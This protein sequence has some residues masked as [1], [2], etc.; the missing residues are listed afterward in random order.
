[1]L[2]RRLFLALIKGPLIG[3]ALAAL[4]VFGLGIVAFGPLL[5]YLAAAATGVATGAL[6]GKPFWAKDAKLE[7]GLKAVVGAFMAVTAMFALRKWLS[8]DL[9]LSAFGA[10]K[11]PL[12]DLPAA[13]L[14]LISFVLAVVF[15][16]DN[17]FDVPETSPVPRQRV[18]TES[19]D[20]RRVEADDELESEPP[21][22]ARS[23]HRT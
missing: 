9:D 3:A 8:F 18:G 1:M 23:R 4:L 2:G 13:S 17:A 19:T 12:G 15:E 11:G 21:E 10:G 6:A 16:A 7:A 20:A 22:R 5:A 14:P